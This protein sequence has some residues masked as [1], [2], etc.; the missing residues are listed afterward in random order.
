MLG[1]STSFNNVHNNWLS[2]TLKIFQ[3]GDK[4]SRVKK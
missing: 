3:S 1:T 2:E 4:L